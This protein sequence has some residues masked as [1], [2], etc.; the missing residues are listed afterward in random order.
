M[1]DHAT[2]LK[3]AAPTIASHLGVDWRVL[4]TDAD[5]PDTVLIDHPNGQAVALQISTY[6]SQDG[7]LFAEGRLPSLPDD[8]N[9]DEVSTYSI[10]TGRI[11]MAP[12]KL[13]KPRQ[14]AGEILRRLLPTLRTGHEAWIAK[15]VEARGKE[16]HRQTA[17][18]LI[19]TVDGIT[20]PTR[21]H[22]SARNHP[23][24]LLLAWDG[25]DRLPSH[26]R[27]LTNHCVPTIRATADAN[28]SAETVM[29]EMRNLTAEAARAAIAAAIAASTPTCANTS[30]YPPEI[31]Q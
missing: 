27:S 6:G 14:V 18:A 3:N 25:Q 2:R 28:D 22:P 11:G 17:A 4:P 15:I 31:P 30:S 20:G 23:H 24:A 26:T 12:G 16:K 19:T 29:V 10:E 21:N 8:V 13:G 5:D 1:T 7:R 9:P